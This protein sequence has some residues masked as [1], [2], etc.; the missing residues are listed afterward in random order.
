MERSIPYRIKLKLDK[1]SKELTRAFSRFDF[2]LTLPVFVGTQWLKHQKAKID[3]K[4]LTN[5]Q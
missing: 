3:K 4:I 5:G 2:Y 1:L